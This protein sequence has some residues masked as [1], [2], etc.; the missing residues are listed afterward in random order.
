MGFLDREKKIFIL[1]CFQK[2]SKSLEPIREVLK[3]LSK[4]YPNTRNEE[5]ISVDQDI[6]NTQ[7]RHLFYNIPEPIQQEI[8]TLLLNLAFGFDPTLVM[9]FLNQ[10]SPTTPPF[11]VAIRAITCLRNILTGEYPTLLSTEIREVLEKLLGEGVPLGEP[12]DQF[13][14]MQKRDMEE[15]K[16]EIGTHRSQ[17]ALGLFQIK[18]QMLM[19]EER[20]DESLSG[21]EVFHQHLLGVNKFIAGAVKRAATRLA[22][23]LS[24]TEASG[25]PPL[26]LPASD[27]EGEGLLDNEA[28]GGNPPLSLP[29]SG[30]ESSGNEASDNEGEGLLDKDDD[31]ASKVKDKTDNEPSGKDADGNPYQSLADEFLY[32]QSLFENNG[33]PGT[34]SQ[35]AK[36]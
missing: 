24:R 32:L 35:V 18:N 7:I 11:R 17:V 12:G 16:V 9:E 34:S 30:N 31:N 27:N 20:I 8:N 28:S 2:D 13:I 25:N 14:E 3:L 10:V 5:G 23:R 21:E 1:E 36:R 26:S 19:E 29:A 33:N 4:K 22:A 15:H 6:I